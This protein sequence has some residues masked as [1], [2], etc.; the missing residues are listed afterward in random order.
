MSGKLV[1]RHVPSAPTPSTTTTYRSL[2]FG[3]G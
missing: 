3:F 1:D 2:L